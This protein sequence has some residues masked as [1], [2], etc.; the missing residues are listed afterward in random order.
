MPANQRE[1]RGW[2]EQEWDQAHGQ[3][4][5][6]GWL[7]GDGTPTEAGRT[8]RAEIELTTD[9]LCE[10]ATAA[11]GLDETDVLRAGVARLAAAVSGS[12]VI[13]YP[14]PTGVPSPLGGAQPE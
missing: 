9:H 10:P 6:R 2:T 3:L 7:H 14:N 12:G 13:P 5:E 1:R 11:L 8:A 4:L